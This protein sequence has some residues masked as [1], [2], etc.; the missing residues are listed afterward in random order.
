MTINRINFQ[1]LI[2]VPLLY[3][4]L[5]TVVF[6]PQPVDKLDPNAEDSL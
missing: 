3:I 4:V 6:P 5:H 2:S 1:Q